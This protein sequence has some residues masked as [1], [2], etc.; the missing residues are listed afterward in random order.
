MKTRKILNLLLLV[1]LMSAVFATSANAQNPDQVALN[2]L[3]NGTYAGSASRSCIFAGLFFGGTYFDENFDIQPEGSE[4]QT[5]WTAVSTTAT[6][7]GDGTGTEVQS[8]ATVTKTGAGSLDFNCDLTY[9]VNFDRSFEVT[10]Q[11]DTIIDDLPF[12]LEFVENGHIQRGGGVLV[13][14]I[15][16]PRVGTLFT[17][18][19][20]EG[21]LDFICVQA[22]TQI[23]MSGP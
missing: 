14:T 7:N 2:K 15:A 6:Y 11:C 8:S 19:F 16:E 10:K 22:G 1:M 12:S 21:F 17:P 4:S 3:L 13:A 5:D 23:K 9:V 20:P 18:G